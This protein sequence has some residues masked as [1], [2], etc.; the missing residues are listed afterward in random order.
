MK[1][2]LRQP[3]EPNSARKTCAEAG[4]SSSRP[5]FAGQRIF[6]VAN[7]DDEVP[8]IVALD[9]G[10]GRWVGPASLEQLLRHAGTGADHSP[11]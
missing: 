7:R 1:L 9:K 3:L 6:N 2:F 10:L 8:N 11:I 5:T 4:D